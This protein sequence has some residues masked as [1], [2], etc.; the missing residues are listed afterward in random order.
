[1]EREIFSPARKEHLTAWCEVAAL[2]E[3]TTDKLREEYVN[4]PWIWE[5][6]PPAKSP[7]GLQANRREF[8]I[9][10][11]LTLDILKAFAKSFISQEIGIKTCKQC[12]HSTCFLYICN[13]LR[14][15]I[16][17]LGSS[18]N[19]TVPDEKRGT[20]YFSATFR[21]TD[22]DIVAEHTKVSDDIIARL[23]EY[24]QEYWTP[25]TN[26]GKNRTY[27]YDIETF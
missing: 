24:D 22:N 15:G 14:T 11:T 6:L 27:L 25:D 23:K 7:S 10:P 16:S 18:H 12:E 13:G 20:Y 4:Y 5:F 2:L 3:G 21:V 26:P 9:N 17:R 8:E 19:T 1:M